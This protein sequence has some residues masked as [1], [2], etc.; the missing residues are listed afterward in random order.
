MRVS[1]RPV[2]VT[3]RVIDL[4]LSLVIGAKTTVPRAGIDSFAG[5]SMSLKVPITD[6]D[7]CGEF[8]ALPLDPLAAERSKVPEAK[9]A[10]TAAMTTTSASVI[11]QRCRRTR[12]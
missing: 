6:P 11:A 7:L 2:D 10:V 5:P 3:V 9:V 1:N 12:R 4:A 8:A